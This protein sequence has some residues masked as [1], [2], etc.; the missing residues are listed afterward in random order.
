MN[1]KTYFEKY[2]KYKNR[3]FKIINNNE[4]IIHIGGSCKISNMNEYHFKFNENG[5]IAKYKIVLSGDKMNLT[6]YKNFNEIES[7]DI[8]NK[9]N[10]YLAIGIVFSVIKEIYSINISMQIKNPDGTNERFEITNPNDNSSSDD[11][12]KSKINFGHVES[13]VPF[14]KKIFLCSEEDILKDLENTKD[15]IEKT[16]LKAI[17]DFNKKIK[18]R[19]KDIN[20]FKGSTTDSTGSVPEKKDMKRDTTKIDT[21]VTEEA[22]IAK[23]AAEE[24]NIAK[25][26]AEEA[27]I[28]KKAAEATKITNGETEAE[29]PDTGKEVVSNQEVAEDDKANAGDNSET[30]KIDDDKKDYFK[31]GKLAYTSNVPEKISEGGRIDITSYEQSI[32]EKEF[33]SMDI[34]IPQKKTHVSGNL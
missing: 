26:A 32:K 34:F 23:K 30:H 25:K 28:A 15:E 4:N 7:I 6:I 12:D 22:N 5:K 3:Y 13:F 11:I 1:N 9:I 33:N 29:A 17:S 24:A 21:K 19:Y 18:E 10:I 2:I 20:P 31:I 16:M 8:E 14:Y 27:N